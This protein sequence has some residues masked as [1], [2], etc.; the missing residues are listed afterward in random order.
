MRRT[1]TAELHVLEAG[2]HGGFFGLA[3]EDKAVQRDVNLFA[4]RD[5]G[6]EAP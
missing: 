5:L 2:G 4:D 1:S 6:R 3:P